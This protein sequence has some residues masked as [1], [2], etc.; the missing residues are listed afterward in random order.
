M[1]AGKSKRLVAIVVLAL[2]GT[3]AA[4]GAV[5]G[6]VLAV[7]GLSGW[8]ND[9]HAVRSAKT[10]LHAAMRGDYASAYALLCSN[11]N[12]ADE[13]L[14]RQRLAGAK[15]AGKAITSFWLHAAFTKETL[16]VTSADGTVRYAN[17]TESDV[18]YDL[19]PRDAEPGPHGDATCLVP[20]GDFS[21]F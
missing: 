3:G 1:T 5:A 7:K 10:Y 17:G 13:E 18:T 14:Y 8:G 19:R 9:P 2:G 20:L 21:T 15:Q 6:T 12:L 11:P 16:N 4:A